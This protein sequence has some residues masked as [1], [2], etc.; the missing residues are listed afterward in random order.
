MDRLLL[1]SS[2]KVRTVL[3][4]VRTV[5]SYEYIVIY[6][7]TCNVYKYSNRT[8]SPTVRTTCTVR[9]VY[10]CKVGELYCTGVVQYTYRYSMYFLAC[11]VLTSS[12]RTVRTCTL[13]YCS[14]LYMIR[15]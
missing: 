5:Y 4:T 13:L 14:D 6:L 9:V 8:V 12:L 7:G 15:Y 10:T 2:A 11:I 1:A 3:S